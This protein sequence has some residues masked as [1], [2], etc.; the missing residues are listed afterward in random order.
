MGGIFKTDCWHLLKE[1]ENWKALT[2]SKAILVFLVHLVWRQRRLVL[3]LIWRTYNTV[4]RPTS[5]RIK[6]D[7]F[8]KKNLLTLL[9]EIISVYCEHNTKYLNML[10]GK[11]QDLFFGKTAVRHTC[12]FTTG[13]KQL[14]IK[15]D[16]TTVVAFYVLLARSRQR[17]ALEMLFR[18][19][20]THSPLSLLPPSTINP[21]SILGAGCRKFHQFSPY[22]SHHSNGH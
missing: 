10:S 12:V 2:V 1:S 3:K 18:R 9:R 6:S 8:I 21:L 7:T 20:E 16:K 19:N 5:Q 11:M 17:N 13:L 4:Y 14:R 22:T 15:F